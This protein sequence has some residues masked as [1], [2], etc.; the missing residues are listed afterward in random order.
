[1]PLLGNHCAQGD[2]RAG[3]NT[4]RVGAVVGGDGQSQRLQIDISARRGRQVE[5]EQVGR[6]I[7]IDPD[8]HQQALG[9]AGLSLNVRIERRRQLSLCCACGIEPYRTAE[10]LLCRRPIA[11]TIIAHVQAEAERPAAARRSFNQRAQGDTAVAPVGQ[12]H[13]EKLIATVGVW[14]ALT[15]VS[16]VANCKASCNRIWDYEFSIATRCARQL[17]QRIKTHLID[18]CRRIG[19]T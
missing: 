18:C 17:T 12:T 11:Y 8:G 13:R 19:R 9:A 15:I 10:I 7:D 14:T 1:M 3:R 5:Q 16:L 6:R 4:V 2:R